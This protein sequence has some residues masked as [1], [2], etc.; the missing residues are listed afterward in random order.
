MRILYFGDA[1][2]GAEALELLLAQEVDIC[3]VVQRV[4]PTDDL[5]AKTA[6]K[7][8]LALYQP[9]S[10][11]AADFL[12]TIAELGPDLNLSV[13][14][15]QILRTPIL[16]SA[17]MGFV[18]FHAG[19]LPYYR[20]RSVLN[21]A[22]INGENEV[23]LTAHFVDEGIDTGDII[24]QR[25]LPVAWEDDYAA[26]LQQMV[27]AFPGLVADTVTLLRSGDFQ[28]QPQAHLPGSYFPRRGPGDEW[29]DWTADSRTA[30]N[31]IRGIAPP[32][33]GAR[34]LLDEQELIINRS[35]YDPNWPCYI[36]TP[37]QVVGVEP[38]GVRIKTADS[39]LL[40]T[41]WTWA[42]PNRKRPLRI[43]D[44]LQSQVSPTLRRLQAQVAALTAKIN[45]T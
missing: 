13:S 40:V 3:G 15:D 42:D 32:G 20:G 12:N 1:S 36:A 22:L 27:A 38:Q 9:P 44:R 21:W 26:V 43:G 2:W 25:T 7:H 31:L 8:G 24:L 14:Y 11:N 45:N 41:D 34:T 23:G 39:T 5:L 29:I 30:Y 19:K 33:P 37:G 4:H 16:E 28:R 10:C 35:Q 18:N 6:D 17:P